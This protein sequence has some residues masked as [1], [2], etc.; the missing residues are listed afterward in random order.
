MRV[1]CRHVRRALMVAASIV[2]RDER[3]AISRESQR[4]EGRLLI[5]RVGGFRPAIRFLG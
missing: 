4:L 3:G 5:G 1:S 2:M